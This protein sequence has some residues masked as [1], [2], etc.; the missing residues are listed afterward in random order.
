MAGKVELD[1]TLWRYGIDVSLRIEA[2][3][4]GVDVNVVD[5]EQNP[6]VDLVGH[7]PQK[8]PFL[9]LRDAKGQ[10]TGNVLDQK[11]PA[12]KILDLPDACGDIS[13]NFVRIGQRQEVMQVM[14]SDSS[15]AEMIGNPRRLEAP[16]HFSQSREIGAVE[17]IGGSD[18]E[19]H[20]VHHD[21]IISAHLFKYAD[22]P[23]TGNH[24]VLGDDLEPA[25]RRTGFEHRSIVITSQSDAKAE[26]WKRAVEHGGYIFI[27]FIGSGCP[28]LFWHSLV[29][30]V[31]M[32]PLPA[33]EFCPGPALVAV[34]H[35][36]CPLQ[37]FAPRHLTLAWACAAPES[38]AKTG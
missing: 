2:M 11:R 3:V 25:D 23:P 16:R 21:W 33:Q 36:L 32:K 29:V 28:P 20:S 18:R 10:V 34:L 13:H 24:K 26:R 1:H 38:A 6:T 5:I 17:G 12:Q 14:P 30:E 27:G 9:H 15:P 31:R 35:A 37:L 22:R 7:R 8:L 19:R 4:E